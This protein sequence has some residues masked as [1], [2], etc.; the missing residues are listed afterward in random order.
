MD[1]HV[2]EELPDPAV[3]HEGGDHGEGIAEARDKKTEAIY[4]DI[5]RYEPEGEIPVCV[6]EGAPQERG[7]IHR[8]Q[9]YENRGGRAS[10]SPASGL[11]A[12]SRSESLVYIQDR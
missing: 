4:R 8:R 10:L 6:G 12:L 11:L 1:E 5:D 2:G 9:W 3:Q 7:S